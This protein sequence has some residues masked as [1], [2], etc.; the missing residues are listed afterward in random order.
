MKVSV[1]IS[2]HHIHLNNED[3]KLLF[4]NTL[5]E[6]RNELKQPGQ[7]ASNLTV[8]I[9]GPKGKIENIRILG[10]N[11]DYTQVEISK[12][13]SYKLGITPPIK[14]S[15][16]L[17]GASLINIIGPYGIIQKECCIIAN[18]HIHV[19]KNILKEKKLEG[20][21]EVKIKIS[22]EKSGIIEHVYLKET[23]KAYFELH[24]D[25]DDANAFLLHQ[26]DVVEI[27]I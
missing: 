25:T 22:G 18:R 1:G 9:E 17:E 10:P 19:D 14:T 21:K 5:M 12:T 24:L 20:I 2:N 16:D 11:R 15:G 23:E 8:D 13:D 26:D 4:G 27:I 3:Y 7:F 6:V